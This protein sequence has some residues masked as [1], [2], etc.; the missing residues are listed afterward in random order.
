MVVGKPCM[1]RPDVKAPQGSGR[2]TCRMDS[3]SPLAAAATSH[4]LSISQGW[5][6][7][8]PRGGH[9]HRGHTK[10]TPI[11]IWPGTRACSLLSA[12]LLSSVEP[13]G[14]YAPVFNSRPPA[15]RC[16]QCQLEQPIPQ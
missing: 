13:F 12:Q 2:G 7:R 8:V 15:R 9:T 10:G 11:L 3:L 5:S 4:Y 16:A 6:G 14:G 1:T